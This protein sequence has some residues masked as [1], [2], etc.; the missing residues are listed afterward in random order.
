MYT[1]CIMTCPK[2]GTKKDAEM[3]TAY[4]ERQY[5]CEACHAKLTVADDECC[6]FCAYSNM[7]CP[8][9]QQKRNCCSD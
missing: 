3:P 5:T 2:C 6:V 4:Q 7:L 1:D 8:I 9:Q